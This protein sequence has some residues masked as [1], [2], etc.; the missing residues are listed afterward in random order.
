MI[1]VNNKNSEFLN[2]FCIS[3]NLHRNKKRELMFFKKETANSI[4]NDEFRFI[5]YIISG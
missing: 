3:G 1:I 2:K 5:V 4:D